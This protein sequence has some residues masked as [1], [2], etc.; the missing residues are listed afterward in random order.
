M[1]KCILLMAIAAI[2]MCIA[3]CKGKQNTT[4]SE[5]A[6]EDSFPPCCPPT[7]FVV[8]LVRL[9]GFSKAEAE[10][11]KRDLEKHLPYIC[12]AYV[13]VE[14]KSVDVP[15]SCLYKPRNRYW[16]GKILDL[17]KVTNPD[18]ASNW[19]RIGLTDKDISTS[20]HGHYNYGVMGLSY[21]PSSS[22]VVSTFRLKHRKDLWKIV[23]HEF[24]HSRGLPHCGKDN[25]KCIIQDAHG[26]D[27][28]YMKN[29]LCNDCKKK[30][31]KILG[32]NPCTE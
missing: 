13:Y 12:F 3:S 17:L 2:A 11:V 6:V 27:T 30:L 1:K 15:A 28:N 20:V 9:D 8:S 26:K 7:D 31:Q 10:T 25:P 32:F 14:D 18:E 29:D 23:V 4:H 16:A 5:D 22:C 21:R 24:L 19:V